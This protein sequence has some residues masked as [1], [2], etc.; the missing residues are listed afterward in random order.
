M[1]RRLALLLTC[2]PLVAGASAPED[3]AR[4]WPLALSAPQAGAYRVELD[5]S[6][7][8]HVQDPAFG[9]IAVLD[10]DG[11]TVPAAFVAPQASTR[12]RRVDAPVFPLPAGSVGAA[13]LRVLAEA[14][15]S[16]RLQRVEVLDA[17]DAAVVDTWIV[18]LRGAHAP[19]SAVEF[20]LPGGA[21]IDR[22]IARV[23]AGDDLDTWWRVPHRGR[24][25][26][27]A[28]NGRRISQR[29]VRFEPAVRARFLRLTFEAAD[30]MPVPATV[31]VLVEQ[32]EPAPLRWESLT[33]TAAA[34]GEFL[35]AFPGRLPVEQV[36]AALTGNAAV[37]WRLSS[38][39][40]SSAA[41]RERA[42]WPAF[43]VESNGR[44]SQSAP[45]ALALP[46][47]DRQWRLQ[48]D[49]PPAQSP[50]LRLG[51]RPGRLVFV[52]Q[53]R[54]PYRLVAGSARARRADAPVDALLADLRRANGA[55]WSPPAAV[56]GPSR[57][58]AGDA[59]LQPRRDRKAWLLWGVLL[60]GA[61]LVAAIA[62]RLLRGAPA[63]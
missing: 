12:P 8:R 2:V 62:L 49:A 22:G 56:P 28:R 39:D 16:G 60:L 18:D 54:P 50:V 47:R 43:R 14:D 13:R 51:Y 24:L 36:D 53:G 17:Q 45:R 20:D 41:W 58:L 4:Q 55:G 29:T 1:T 11:R 23:E 33:A 46:V 9:D 21:T 44:V 26:D 30:T 6:V 48:A 52:A 5:A 35:F 37:R 38:R 31:A 3:Y 25:V 59:A 57:A 7:Y 27:L 32:A 19:V 40:A 42:A 63:R 15:A 61:G 34:P 10:A